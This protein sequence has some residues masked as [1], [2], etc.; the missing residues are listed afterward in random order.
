MKF[1]WL[2]RV[3]EVAGHHLSEMINCALDSDSVIISVF[4]SD[5]GFAVG[6]CAKWVR[7]MFPRDI[8]K[9]QGENPFEMVFEREL[10][11]VNLQN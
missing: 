7:S 9:F 10:L 5:S 4:C 6:E 1:S 3:H 8:Y 11:S 2:P